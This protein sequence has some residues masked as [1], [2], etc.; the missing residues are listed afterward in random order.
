[1]AITDHEDISY[2]AK[3]KEI[4]IGKSGL[5]HVYIQVLFA[6][7]PETMPTNERP[8]AF[9]YEVCLV[10]Q[11]N[12][13]RYHQRLLLSMDT[14]CATDDGLETTTSYLGSVFELDKGDSLYVKV[15]KIG[16]VKPVPHMNFFGVY[17]L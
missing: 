2:V 10:K 7:N 12:K 1:M 6:Y 3:D 14:P 11:K 4:R 8:L 15:S 13:G 5:Y 17:M 9:S 16:H